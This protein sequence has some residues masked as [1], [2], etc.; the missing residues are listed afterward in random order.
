MD[1]YIWLVEALV[2]G[3]AVH[4]A[5]IRLA[6]RLMTRQPRNRDRCCRRTFRHVTACKCEHALREQKHRHQKPG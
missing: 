2:G 6:G 4:E 3:E 5:Q 1:G